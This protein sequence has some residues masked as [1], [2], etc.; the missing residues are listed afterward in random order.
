[1]AYRFKSSESSSDAVARIVSEELRAAIDLLR[2]SDHPLDHRV[3]E[4]RKHLKKSRAILVLAR[5][6]VPARPF[7]REDRLLRRAGRSLATLRGRAALT[8]CFEALSQHPRSELGETFVQRVRE[9][10]SKSPTGKAL[11]APELA[12]TH[13]LLSRAKRRLKKLSFRGSGWRALRKGFRQTYADA[14]RALDRAILEPRAKAL[15]ALRIPAKRH[16]YQIQ[17]LEP[18]SPALL[19]GRLADLTRLAGLLG[20]HHDLSL[21]IPELSS[22]GLPQGDLAQVRALA[23]H[24]SRELEVQIFESA[25]RLFEERP[26][27]IT[28]RLGAFLQTLR[29]R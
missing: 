27:A 24:R 17:V 18:L 22:R 28:R 14:R 3:H 9:R 7:Q 29:E 2:S 19:R 13:K 10:L 12:R 20:D 11:P 8:T 15:H 5:G 6:N 21:L 25:R 16:L 23:L 26:R 1:M 4:V